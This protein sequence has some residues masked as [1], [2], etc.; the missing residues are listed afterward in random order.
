[1]LICSPQ[2]LAFSFCSAAPR[3]LKESN[4]AALNWW[5]GYNCSKILFLVTHFS[6]I[7]AVHWNTVDKWFECES[8]WNFNTGVI[9]QQ[10]TVDTPLIP[11]E[12]FFFLICMIIFKHDYLLF[13]FLWLQK[14]YSNLQRDFDK[15]EKL[16]LPFKIKWHWNME[17]YMMNI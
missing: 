6:H 5:V 7:K 11:H 10:N 12:F 16:S 8:R 17:S 4:N 1:M 3:L 2:Q 14:W 9:L 15:M 13:P